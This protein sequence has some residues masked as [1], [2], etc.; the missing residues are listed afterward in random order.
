MLS[1]CQALFE[2][3]HKYYHFRHHNEPD[4]RSL[5]TPMLPM[6]KRNVAVPDRKLQGGSRGVPGSV[7]PEPM[8]FRVGLWASYKC[9]CSGPQASGV[10][11][12]ILI[13]FQETHLH[14]KV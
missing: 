14:N 12:C 1:K 11:I 7:A 10:R 4:G 5:S 2:T 3:L 9:R 6:G 13:R 8:L